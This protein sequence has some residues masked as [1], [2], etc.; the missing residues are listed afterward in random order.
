VVTFSTPPAQAL[1]S[2]RLAL[3]QLNLVWLEEVEAMVNDPETQA[4]TGTKK[5]FTR[6]E[7]EHW[8]STRSQ[9]TERCDWAILDQQSGEFLGEVVLNELH[10]EKA[11]M[12]MRIALANSGY[13]GRG[14]GT[15]TLELVLGFAFDQLELARVTLSV[16]TTN[17][18][19]HRCYEKVGFQ[20]GRQYNDG[21]HRY[22]RMSVTKAQ[23]VE[24]LAKKHMA[25]HLDPG[26]Q[27]AYDNGK[28][29][30]GL[31]NYQSKTIS[32]SKYVL[33]HHP[34]DDSVQVIWHEIAHALC[35]KEVGHGK[36]W[37]QTAKQLGY[38]AE[39]FSG[40]TIAEN[41]APWVGTCPAGHQHFRYRKP[42]S[43]LSCGVCGRGFR[44]AN[45]ITWSRVAT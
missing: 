39:K 18:R 40:K 15:E 41:T 25:Q 1:S 5:R 11:S 29:R 2:D 35:G 20:D 9:Q 26:W 13:F 3:R 28:R 43:V 6:A 27:F 12:N 31:C 42:T 8:L 22:Q 36:L 23:F 10:A 45:L 34:I 32:L 17:A 19:A 16:L 14:I 44:Q 4:L 24:A 7:L 33:M 21:G 38:R 37:L 30:A